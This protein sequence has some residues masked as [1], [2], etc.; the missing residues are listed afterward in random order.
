MEAASPP[1]TCAPPTDAVL[2]ARFAAGEGGAKE[3]QTAFAEVV[4]RH[5]R[6]VY[7]TARRV[8][9][10]HDEA[11]DVSQ[12]VFTLLAQKVRSGLAVRD[13]VAGWLHR[14]AVN[15]SR[16]ALRA[17]RTRTKL[18]SAAAEREAPQPQ[19]TALA[20][21]LDE[22]LT[23]MPEPDRDLILRRYGEGLS[24]R[25][26]SAQTGKSEAAVQKQAVRALEKLAARLRQRGVTVP[27][28]V[29]SSILAADSG[30][31]LPAAEMAARALSVTAAKNGGALAGPFAVMKLTKL[32]WAAALLA[33]LTPVA[34]ESVN[35]ASAS[36]GSRKPASAIPPGP[37]AKTAPA[38]AQTEKFPAS[39]LQEI[40]TTDASKEPVRFLKLAARLGTLT[41]EEVATL[42]N[43]LQHAPTWPRGME[44]VKSLF[45]R[46]AELDADA[47]VRAGL[48]TSREFRIPQWEGIASVLTAREGAAYFA[49]FYPGG[50]IPW[51]EVNADTG[52]LR[53]QALFAGF[54]SLGETDPAKC[55]E[56]LYSAPPGS[57]RDALEYG[58]MEGAAGS[59][60]ESW[61]AL[62]QL[63]E[64]ERRGELL[65]A[66]CKQMG[67]IDP[68]AGVELLKRTGNEP[69][70]AEHLPGMMGALTNVDP[71]GAVTAWAQL[72]V[73]L[74]TPKV[75]YSMLSGRMG[76]TYEGLM[77]L[78]QPVIDDWAAKEPGAAGFWR[79]ENDP[80]VK[81]VQPR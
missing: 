63:P 7:V 74:R 61:K 52:S 3:S 62:L 77:Q 11:Q 54:L 50:V 4:A 39:L 55:V 10:S 26:L 59:P 68:A 15:C 58:V 14:V 56:M 73:E 57:L 71:R 24:C 41:K 6:L 8:L 44:A 9:S 17:R 81:R 18:E 64:S 30:S 65:K 23:T 46:W 27:A 53:R 2:L 21:L 69:F 47:A 66:F 37:P 40:A 36:T 33:F 1:E 16:E 76:L 43:S 28:A 45:A 75:T 60:E 25:E 80:L 78:W 38:A 35:H 42:W 32:T 70:A 51:E 79:K 22:T 5:S 72:P 12:R 20:S 67:Q 49:R 29:V 19:D 31:P 34:M 48:E 13:S